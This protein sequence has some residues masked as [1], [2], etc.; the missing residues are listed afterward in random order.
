MIAILCATIGLLAGTILGFCLGC[1][2]SK[3]SYD[4]KIKTL[5]EI[6]DIRKN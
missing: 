5:E 2:G 3:A 6:Y 1:I 4:E